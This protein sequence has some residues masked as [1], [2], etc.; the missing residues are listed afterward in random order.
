M[1]A[2][3]SGIR[4]CSLSP[5]NSC[6]RKAVYNKW[7]S[8]ERV[9]SRLKTYRKLDSPRTRRLPKVWIHVAFSIIIL[10][11]VALTITGQNVA[12]LRRCVA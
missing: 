4:C 10:N 8:V 5:Y 12:N 2:R 11:A 1:F 6:R 7:V 9:F 3:I